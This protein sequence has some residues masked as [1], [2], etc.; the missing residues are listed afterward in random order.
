MIALLY[1]SSA[2]AQK[3]KTKMVTVDSIGWAANSI[4]VTVFRKNSLVSFKDT[5]Y[6]AFYNKDGF[7]VLGKRRVGSENWS[8]QQTTYRGNTKD[9]HCTISIMVDGDG[10][11]HLAWDHHNNALNYC[12]SIAPGSLT[13]T[14]KLTMTGI[15]ESKVTYPEFYKIAD[16]NLLFFFRDGGS[17]NGNLVINKYD[18]R[19]QKWTQI[20][21]NL[22]DGEKKRNAYWQACVDKAGTIHIS[23]VWRESADVASNHDL[24]YAASKDGGLTWEK[25]DA[26]KYIL[27]INAATAEYIYRVPQKS[28]LINQTSMDADENGEPYIATYWREPNDSVPQYHVVFKANGTWQTQNLGF[29]KTAFSLSGKGTKRIPIS[30]P[31]IVVWNKKGTTNTAVIFRDEERG[32]VVSVALNNDMKTNVW[33]IKNLSTTSV[34]S[35]EPTYDTA[36]WKEKKMLHLFVQSANQEDNEG[37]SSVLPQVVRVLECNFKR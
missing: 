12:K 1:C 20:Q 37:I 17:G 15:N 25:S 36:L 23:W 21:S 16:G 19:T 31:Q 5:Q 3:V 7:V 11:L 2:Q 26:E 27:P 29:K 9:A 32:N 4:N 6:I 14:A 13:L 10:Y 28:E 8:L 35:W 34:G 18:I 22:I 24:C 33:T 30:R